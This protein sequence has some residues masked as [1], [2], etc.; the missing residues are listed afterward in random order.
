MAVKTSAPVNKSDL[1][2][3]MQVINKCVAKL[4]VKIADVII[5]D[6]VEGVNLIATD[7]REVK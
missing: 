1:L 5:K 7:N 6:L 4:P 3:L 2:D